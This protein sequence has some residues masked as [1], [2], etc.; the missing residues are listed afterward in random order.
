[1]SNLPQELIDAILERVEDSES[2]KACSLVAGSFLAPSQ[3]SLFR[4]LRLRYNILKALNA[5][6]TASARLA[7]YIRDVQIHI[8]LLPHHQSTLHSVLRLLPNIARMKIYGDPVLWS[9]ISE[10]LRLTLLNVIARPSFQRLHLL[11]VHGVPSAFVLWA[12]SS[13]VVLSLWCITIEDPK[14]SAVA[15]PSSL[16]TP[17]RELFIMY[18]LENEARVCDLLLNNRAHLAGLERLRI[19]IDTLS[20]PYST[21]LLAAGGATLRHLEFDQ[22]IPVP[23]PMPALPPMPHVH[24]V[25]LQVSFPDTGH[26]PL[27]LHHTLTQLAAALPNL[28][29]ITLHCN[30]WSPSPPAD[31]PPVIHRTKFPHLRQ[32]DCRV[33]LSPNDVEQFILQRL[34]ATMAALIPWPQGTD[35][36]HCSFNHPRVDF[37]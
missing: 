29:V 10:E 17:L 1:M 18:T 36:L 26:L 21:R 19:Q 27:H 20:A 23:H 31:P 8:P 35:I 33:D 25:A 3:R 2:L 12:A 24:T 13:V 30:I 16:A 22:Y 7:S 14:S 9:D 28:E 15:Q 32:I 5:L 11:Y 34:R 37:P 4:Y 6:F